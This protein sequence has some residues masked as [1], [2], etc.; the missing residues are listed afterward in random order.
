MR[1]ERNYA[2]PQ[3]IICSV[4]RLRP[5]HST[6]FNQYSEVHVRQ[7]MWCVIFLPV[8]TMAKPKC[9]FYANCQVQLEDAAYELKTFHK[10]N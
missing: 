4:C 2:I 10:I 5:I 9:I 1:N 6:L 7:N 3:P 8:V